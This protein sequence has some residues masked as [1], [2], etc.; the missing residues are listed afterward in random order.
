[1]LINRSWLNYILIVL[2]VVFAS[3][4]HAVGLGELKVYS[5]L[6]EPLVAEIE[7]LNLE[8]I[9][10][11]QLVVALASQEDFTRA[12]VSRPYFLSKSINTYS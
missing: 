12:K 6:D 5:F 4:C 2:G 1:M 11:N 3:I 10:P 9:D 8:R 7:V